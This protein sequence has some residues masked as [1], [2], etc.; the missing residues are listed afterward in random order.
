MGLLAFVRGSVTGRGSQCRLHIRF[1]FLKFRRPGTT[2]R[3]SDSVGVSC[4][5][6]FKA[7]SK[8]LG[9][10]QEF[11]GETRIPYRTTTISWGKLLTLS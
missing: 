10:N 9:P 4:F 7:P 1:R 3:D 5:V 8:I 6:L 2:L 11:Y